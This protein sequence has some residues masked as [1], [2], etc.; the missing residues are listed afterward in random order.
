MR[1]CWSDGHTL[2]SGSI[3]ARELLPVERQVSVLMMDG[4]Q[5]AREVTVG[6]RVRGTLLAEQGQSIQRFAADAFQR[7]PAKVW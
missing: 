5:A 7:A 3:R 1:R 2:A 6:D 4:Y